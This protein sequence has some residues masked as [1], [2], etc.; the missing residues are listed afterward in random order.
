MSPAISIALLLL[1]AT[2]VKSWTSLE[3]KTE[4][5]DFPPQ[6]KHDVREGADHQTEENR[7]FPGSC[8]ACKFI[9]S[10]VKKHLGS[11]HSKNKIKELLNR[12]CNGVKRILRSACKSIVNK[13]QQKLI[14]ALTKLKSQREICVYLKLCKK[15]KPL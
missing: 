6:L 1:S 9:V 11:D 13:F 10:K 2:V 14:N 12:A 15:N 7:V 3:V 8:T 5:D 4:G